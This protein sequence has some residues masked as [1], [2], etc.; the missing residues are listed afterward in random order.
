MRILTAL[1]AI[2]VVFGSSTAAAQTADD[3]ATDAALLEAAA[4]VIVD[5]LAHLQAQGRLD[6][7]TSAL[8][9]TVPALDDSPQVIAAVLERIDRVDGPSVLAQLDDAGIDVAPSV[10]TVLS[11]QATND[12]EPVSVGQYVTA[13][14]MLDRIDPTPTTSAPAALDDQ[15][16]PAQGGTAWLPLLAGAGGVVALVAAFVGSRRLG[17]RRRRGTDRSAAPASRNVD[18]AKSALQRATSPEE[19]GAAVCEHLQT[20]TGAK[21]ILFTADRINARAGALVEAPLE[22]CR[23]AQETGETLHAGRLSIVPVVDHA[24]PIGTIALVGGDSGPAE[25]LAPAIG[26]ATRVVNAAMTSDAL[27]YLDPTT[28]VWNLRRFRHDIRDEL[29]D[30]TGIAR[31]I[32]TVEVDHYDVYLDRNGED[33]AQLALRRVATEL[34]DG[35]RGTDVVYRVGAARFAVLLRNANPAQAAHVAERVRATVAGLTF[36]G[37]RAMPGGRVT[38]SAGVA[39]T[40]SVVSAGLVEASEDA[41]AA[42]QTGGRN[43]VVTT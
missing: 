41:L 20:L 19:L 14:R 43:V 32:I 23:A 3:P 27:V 34:V 11:A 33:T 25:T 24:G 15:P 1:L 10:R 28:G 16:E 36:P 18:A 31:S 6:G 38:V 40:D 9:G 21:G 8:D 12:T 7:D 26:S 29:S 2:S 35:V 22:L 37:G 42:A 4:D 5:E 17:R 30:S 13:L 39:H